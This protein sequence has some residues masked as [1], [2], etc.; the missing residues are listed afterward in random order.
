MYPAVT[1]SNALQMFFYFAFLALSCG[2]I[3]YILQ[4]KVVLESE[5]VILAG[6]GNLAYSCTTISF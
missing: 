1:G 3:V 6:N 4:S 2:Y 5:A